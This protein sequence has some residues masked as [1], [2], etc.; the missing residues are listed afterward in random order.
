M[1]LLWAEGISGSGQSCNDSEGPLTEDCCSITVPWLSWN[2]NSL[3]SI[4]FCSWQ[5]GRVKVKT[6]AQQEAEKTKEREKKLKIYVAARDACFSKVLSATLSTCIDSTEMLVF[7]I[8]PFVFLT[9]LTLNSITSYFSIGGMY[10]F[11]QISQLKR[12][13]WCREWI[14]LVQICLEDVWS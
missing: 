6:T 7:L 14:T 11:N 3:I 4:C 9:T 10:N 13:S 8:F 2:A 5:H 12:A 1:V